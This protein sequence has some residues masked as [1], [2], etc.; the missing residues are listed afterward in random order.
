MSESGKSAGHCRL[1]TTDPTKGGVL[2]LL[3]GQPTSPERRSH[4]KPRR[5]STPRSSSNDKHTAAGAMTE[6]AR[7]LGLG[8]SFAGAGEGLGCGKAFSGVGGVGCSADG[9]ALRLCA[10]LLFSAG[11]RVFALDIAAAVTATFFSCPK[12]RR[13]T[14]CPFV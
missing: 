8:S 1:P 4:T 14:A 10:T 6:R 9:D 2:T 7:A 13:L 11:R 3:P 12:M 5:L